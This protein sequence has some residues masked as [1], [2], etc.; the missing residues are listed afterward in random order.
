MPTTDTAAHLAALRD[1]LA[2]TH[3]VLQSGTRW[4]DMRAARMAQVAALEWAIATLEAPAPKAPPKR[5]HPLPDGWVPNVT[6]TRLA[7]T[8]GLNLVA[9]A[10]AFIDHAET[11]NR[12]AVNWDAAFR[13][14]LRKA[15]SFAAPKGQPSRHTGFATRNY[16]EGLTDDGAIADQ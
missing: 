15:Q 4:D 8:L 1:V 6:H 7:A 3:K 9:Q 10:A 13:M 5:A 11:H 14:W 2:E 12:K 16:R